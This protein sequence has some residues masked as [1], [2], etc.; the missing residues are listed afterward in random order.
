MTKYVQSRLLQ[1][2]RMRERVN[3]LKKYLLY[4][5]LSSYITGLLKSTP[6]ILPGRHLM[7]GGMMAS[8]IGAY[9]YFMMGSEYT[10]GMGMLGMATSLSSVLGVTLTMAIGGKSSTLLTPAPLV[11]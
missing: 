1:N 4:F 7:N 10:E 11:V 5:C 9:S 2:C 8:N 3:T 6:T